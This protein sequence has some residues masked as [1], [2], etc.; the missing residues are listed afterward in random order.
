MWIIPKNLHTSVYV[1]DTAALIWDLKELSQILELLLI[2]R[3]KLMQSSTWLQKLKRDTWTQR[4]YGRILKHSHTQTFTKKLISLVVASHASHLAPQ[5]KEMG[6][7]TLDT[8]GPTLEK[9]LDLLSLPLFSSKTYKEYLAQN[10][11]APL[12]QTQKARQYYYTSLENWK[13]LII[14]LRRAYSQRVKLAPHIKESESSFLQYQTGLQENQKKVLLSSCKSIKALQP[15]QLLEGLASTLGR[16]LAWSTPTAC[17]YKHANLSQKAIQKRTLDK[18]QAGIAMQALNQQ[19]KEKKR[20]LN[21]RW[22]E[23]IMGLPVG[24]TQVTSLQL[25]ITKRTNLDYL[26]MGL[27]LIP[28]QKHFIPCGMNWPTPAARD[29]KCSLNTV[30]PCT[31]KTRGET[32]SNAIVNTEKISNWPTPPASQR[33]ED[34]EVYIRKSVNRIK[35]GGQ[36]FA[37]TLQVSVEA[38]EKRIELNKFQKDVLNTKLS[39]EDFVKSI[40]GK[41]YKKDKTS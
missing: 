21:P 12:G 39:T 5:V 29:Y 19:N 26:A 13:K 34:L 35:A 8:C 33:G 18:R 6:I 24:W 28:P 30:P 9:E 40:M 2:V 41:Y 3:S 36:K 17:E 20:Y 7:Q 32:L 23:Q 4:L 16:R 38:E 31:G 25:V 37:P 10:L 1:P 15:T 14:R 27:Y 11:K 22:V